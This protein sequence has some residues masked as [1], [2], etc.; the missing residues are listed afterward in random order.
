MTTMW[1]SSSISRDW[2]CNDT[3]FGCIYIL[4]LITTNIYIATDTSNMNLY[5]I[6]KALKQNLTTL[7]EL[8]SQLKLM[9]SIYV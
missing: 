7:G 1:K 3:Q 2:R 8:I 5:C 6:A 4:Q 9:Q